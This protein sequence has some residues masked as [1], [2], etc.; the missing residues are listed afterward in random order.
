MQRKLARCGFCE[1]IKRP[2]ELKKRV[3]DDGRKSCMVILARDPKVVGHTLI[4][5]RTHY[6][7]ITDTRLSRREALEILDAVVFW[8]RRLKAILKSPKVEKVYVMTMC[9][10]WTPKER[11]G[12]PPTEHL[13]FHLLPRYEDMRKKELAQEHLFARPEEHGWTNEMFQILQAKLQIRD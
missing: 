4:V 5:S 10:Y 7:D 12:K 2:S 3:L 13:H 9:E 11:E 1:L 8:C 6:R